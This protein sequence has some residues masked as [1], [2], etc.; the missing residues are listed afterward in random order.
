MTLATVRAR[1]KLRPPPPRAALNI[2]RS[3]PNG[4]YFTRNRSSSGECRLIRSG[5][6]R[7]RTRG[8]HVLRFFQTGD[9]GGRAKHADARTDARH[10]TR[11]QYPRGDRGLETRDRL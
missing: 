6:A 11:I 3:R 7:G 8:S 5:A 1:P 2:A 10:S 9:P 4:Y